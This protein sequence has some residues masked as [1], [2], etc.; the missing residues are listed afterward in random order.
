M[1]FMNVSTKKN[2]KKSVNITH[3]DVTVWLGIYFQSNLCMCLSMVVTYF[4]AKKSN[5]D[6]KSVTEWS[7]MDTAQTTLIDNIF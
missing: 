4:A 6:V 1:D 7:R 2:N 5:M 3:E